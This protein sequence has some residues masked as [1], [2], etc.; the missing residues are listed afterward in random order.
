[1]TGQTTEKQQV[2][3]PVSSVEPAEKPTVYALLVGINAYQAD[4]ILQGQVRFPALQGCVEDVTKVGDYLRHDASIAANIKLLADTN[5]S[6]AAIVQ[7]FREHLGKAKT[8]DVALF[9][10]SG[11]G[12]QEHADTTI[13][14]AETDGLLECIACYYDQKTADDFLLA[15]KELRYLIQQL[16]QNQ[17]HVVAIFDCC[18]SGDNTRNGEQV[19]AAF[20]RAVEKRIPFSF[21]TRD[22]SRFIFSPTIS[23]DVMKQQGAAVLLPEGTHVQLSA[24]ESDESAMEVGGAGVFTKTLLAVL[25][26]SGGAVSYHS[27]QSRVRQYLRNVFQ[28]QPRIYVAN[29]DDALLYSNFLNHPGQPDATTTG[30]I[31]FNQPVGQAGSWL[32]NLGAIHG[33]SKTTP[34]FTVT[35]PQHPQKTYQAT[36]AAVRV[37]TAQLVFADEAPADNTAVYQAII[38]GLM[39]KPIAVTVQN[40][41]GPLPEQ[42]LLMDALLA[43]TTGYV[44][45]EDDESQAAYVVHNQ[46][47]RYYITYPGDPYRPLTSL[48]KAGTDAAIAELSTQLGQISRWEFQKALTNSEPS[49]LLDKRL[50]VEFFQVGADGVPVALPVEAGEVA[51]PYAQ[52]PDG[53]WACTLQVKLTNPTDTNLYC[54]VAYLSSSFESGLGF[55]NPTTYLLNGQKSVFLNVNGNSSFTTTLPEFLPYYKWPFSREY[56]KLIVSKEYF[57]VAGLTLPT[58][59]LPPLPGE[60]IEN[61]GLRSI[62]GSATTAVNLQGWTTQLYTL[63]FINPLP[64]GVDPAKRQAMLNDPQTAYFAKGLYGESAN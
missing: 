19:M 13:W 56:L 42:A 38:G 45:A 37:D 48:A 27:L 52:Q 26:K 51:F 57:D 6:K 36:V 8:G 14:T 47:G 46:G 2:T 30:E 1:M 50:T 4:L 10:F 15:D 5:A 53:T 25:Q 62:F 17:P 12:T 58:L 63:K 24:C 11:H 34:A 18:H 21:P 64:E 60:P 22:W 33:I 7:A 43:K 28:Q 49:T 16:S 9:Y 35:D 59:P 32:L 3:L 29:G 54:A 20:E 44:T 39:T 41:D 31:V 61:K 23:A 40:V 55:L